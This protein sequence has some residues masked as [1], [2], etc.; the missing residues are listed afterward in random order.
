[1]SNKG[2]YLLIV[3]FVFASNQ[4]SAQSNSTIWDDIKGDATHSL[5]MGIG[6][7]KSPFTASASDWQKIGIATAG[8]GLLF[9]ADPTVKDLAQNNQGETGD[10]IFNIDKTFNKEYVIIGSSGLYLSGL[11]FRQRGIRRTA[12]YTIESVFIAS[13]ITGSL[14]IIFGRSRPFVDEGHLKFRL[15]GGDRE[16]HRSLPSGHATG[17]FSI[18]TVFAK[19]IDNIWWKTF[20]YG[21]AV[22]VG[23]A[24]VYHNRHWLSDTVLGGF[25]GYTTASYVVHFDDRNKNHK[26]SFYG[27]VIQPYFS[28]NEFGFK[29]YF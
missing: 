2:F 14:K 26:I 22:M 21:T 17:A 12:L 23:A 29:L 4:I 15:F 18:C 7:L 24:R 5:N 10:W 6:L 13:S 9:M 25:I 27:D 1:M 16:S 28:L 20:W 8:T 3:V 19:S 11:I